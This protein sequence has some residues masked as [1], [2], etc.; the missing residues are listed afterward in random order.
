MGATFTPGRMTASI[1]IFVVATAF[2]WWGPGALGIPSYFIPPL[3]QVLE[4]FV[5]LY[6]RSDLLWHALITWEQVML[7]FVFGALFG[8]VA[9]YFLG[10]S[11]TAE[12]VLSPYILALQIAPKVAFAPLFVL[13]LGFGQG[14]RI[15]TAALIVFFPILVNV[16]SAVRNVDYDL[17][18]LARSFKATRLQIFWRIEFPASM[19][20]LFAGLRIGATLAVIG[21]TVGEFVGGNEGLGVLLTISAGAAETPVVF[22]VII[23]QTILGL[24][25]Y[26]LVVFAERRVLHY[27]PSRGLEGL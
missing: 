27:M 17:I 7:G 16:M 4:G 1:A 13:W 25:L 23:A 18:N 20:P 6:V 22:A 2:W 24:M 3:P 9:G 26:F 12:I 10:M 8:M 5:D 21:V 19:P 11:V 15:L 14:P